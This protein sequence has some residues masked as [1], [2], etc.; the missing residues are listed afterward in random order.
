MAEVEHYGFKADIKIR[1]TCVTCGRKRPFPEEGTL[2]LSNEQDEA[3]GVDTWVQCGDGGLGCKDTRVTVRVSVEM[4]DETPD[5][6]SNQDDDGAPRAP[7]DGA[8]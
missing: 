2:L 7:T 3:W 4:S 8:G 1:V 5:G 6:D